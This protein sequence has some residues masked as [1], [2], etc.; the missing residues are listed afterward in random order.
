MKHIMLQPIRM[1]QLILPISF[2][3]LLVFSLFLP[4]WAMAGP[5]LDCKGSEEAYRLQGIPCRCING[6][7]VCDQPSGKSTSHSVNNAV[8]LQLFQGLLDAVMQGTENNATLQQQQEAKHQYD[9]QRKQKERELEFNRQKNFAE[10]KDKLLGTLKGAGTGK[11]VDFKNLDGDAE[12]MRKAA[13]DPFDQSADTAAKA[14]VSAGTN[15]F[16]TKL[17]EP[18]ITTLME[19]KNDPIIVDLSKA[20][21][22]I[23]QNLKQN[24]T[25]IKKLQKQKTQRPACK[26]IIAKYN[27]QV[28]D[29][30]K[31]Q[32]QIEFTQSQLDE[33][34]QKNDAAFW[35]A[36]IDGASFAIGEYFDYLK[37]TR[38][39]AENVKHNLELIETKLINEKVYTPAQIAGL[40][41]KLNVRMAEHTMAKYSSD[42]SNITDYFDHV[43]NTI[44][45]SVAEIGKTDADIKEFL[46]NPKVREYLSEYP[47]T[48]AAQFVAGKYIKALLEKKGFTKYSY[49]S[50]AQLAVNTVYNAT[51]MYLSYKNICTL[52][53]ASG[54]EFAAVRH[55]QSQISNTYRK[56]VECNK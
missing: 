1:H 23:V 33:W 30:K 8:K 38:K 18:E 42:F 52:R 47:T 48:D 40:K 53:N 35:N 12:A 51:D 19:S 39:G 37:E 11:L 44:Q 16:G 54:K 5:G 21:T 10:K 50:I 26:E 7:I 56:I 27:R 9:L 6:K 49:V 25:A 15:F 36:V 28:D 13:G 45:S 3:G 24:E 22:F 43:K 14:K 17:S 46:S 32:K 31:F 41:K 29:M 55:I 2:I 4:Q 34:R 20:N